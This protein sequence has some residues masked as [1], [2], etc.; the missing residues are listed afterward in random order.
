MENMRAMVLNKCAPIE[1][2]PLELTEISRHRVN[3]PG[4]VLVKIDACGVCHSQ[5]HSIEGD[6]KDLG[7]PPR[8]PTVPGHEVVGTVVETGNDVAAIAVGDRVGISPL[9]E[10]CL[11]CRYCNE[12][13]EQ[14]CESM[15]VLGESM[16]GGYAEYV[17]VSERFATRVPQTMK[18][19]YAA[20]LFC[21]GVTAYGA[22]RACD[23]KEGDKVGIFGIGGVGHMAVQFAKSDGLEVTAVSRNAGHLT[24]ASRLGADRTVGYSGRDA[25]STEVASRGHLDSAMVF[26]PNDDVTREALASIKRGGTL[27]VATV[28][29][30]PDFVAF[31]EKTVRGTLIGSRADMANVVRIAQEDHI[32][33]VHET[34]PLESA[35]EA[36]QK[37]K[38]SRLEARAVLVP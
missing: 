28:G 26:A 5:L 24:V 2:N 34:F 8:L 37:L 21:A 17:T 32:E 20:P 10:S 11:A 38:N 29:G 9:L 36:L 23:A 3:R 4:D 30:I 13:K 14:L 22:V 31:E 25:T 7:I 1:T 33:V 16:N 15:K 35:N 18:P 12:G 27:V 6:W 19:S